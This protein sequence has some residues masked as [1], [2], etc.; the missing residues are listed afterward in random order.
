[1]FRL[2]EDAKQYPKDGGFP[3]VAR[4]TFCLFHLFNRNANALDER[5]SK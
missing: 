1:M 3:Q 4:C 2:I 5:P